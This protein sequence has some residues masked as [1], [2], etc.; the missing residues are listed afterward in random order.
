LSRPYLRHSFCMYRACSW[1]SFE[2]PTWGT[3]VKNLG[4]IDYETTSAADRAD[5]LTALMHRKVAANRVT[6]FWLVKMCFRAISFGLSGYQR[7]RA[8]TI[9]DSEFTGARRES[10]LSKPSIQIRAWQ[11][12]RQRTPL[13][14]KAAITDIIAS[15]GW[16]VSSL[17][18]H[19]PAWTSAVWRV[20]NAY[21][22]L[23]C[24]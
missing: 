18:C 24:Y 13:H 12:N 14:T 8:F 22:D 21:K 19:K 6:L 17:G 16:A 2:P 23:Y 3:L 11:L 15:F 10:P 4:Y 7:W 9:L 5:E 20:F 1:L